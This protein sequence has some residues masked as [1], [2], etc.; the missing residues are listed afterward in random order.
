ML[1]CHDTPVQASFAS[2]ATV[3]GIEVLNLSSDFFLCN[4]LRCS[5]CFGNFACTMLLAPA[6]TFSCHFTS[7]FSCKVSLFRAPC[8]AF[9]YSRYSSTCLGNFVEIDDLA[10]PTTFHA[11]F[12]YDPSVF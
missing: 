9:K 5:T 11:I 10:L 4:F 3:V 6:T 12:A 7:V 2:Q 8:R 1:F